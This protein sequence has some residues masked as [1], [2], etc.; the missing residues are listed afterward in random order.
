MNV[1]WSHE[2]NIINKYIL[3]KIVSSVYACDGADG[4]QIDAG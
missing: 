2:N 1:M 3:S 4:L